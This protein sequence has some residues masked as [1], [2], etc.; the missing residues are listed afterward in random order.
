MAPAIEKP[1]VST[2]TVQTPL[3]EKYTAV[4]GKE[5]RLPI[6]FKSAL[7]Y[8]VKWYAIDR[9]ITKGNRHDIMNEEE[10]TTLIIKSVDLDDQ[11]EYTLVIS[12][13]HE[14]VSY[15]TYLFVDVTKKLVAEIKP[16]VEPVKI[17]VISRNL[18]PVIKANIGENVSFS[19]NCDV[20]MP[21]TKV[22]WFHNQ[23]NI[24]E[25]LSKKNERYEYVYQPETHTSTLIIKS[26][27]GKDKGE[28][29]FSAKNNA[30]VCNST[31]ILEVAG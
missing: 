7:K 22:E 28:Y 24:T 11:C 6:L 4:Q 18:E 25:K 19:C 13:E 9:L 20:S 23:L 8:N 30:G 27:K 26:V 21:S 1:Q 31:C 29:K 5:F 14:S 2:L 17:P 10:S 15:K 16:K 12:N 3:Q